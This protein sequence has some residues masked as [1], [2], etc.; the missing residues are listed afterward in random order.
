MK[1]IKIYEKYYSINNDTL[2][3]FIKGVCK[4]FGNKY[5]FYTINGSIYI[6]DSILAVIIPNQNIIICE[7]TLFSTLNCIVFNIFKRDLEINKLLIDYFS[8]IMKIQY[9][10]HDYS[11]IYTDNTKLSI[12]NF[13]KLLVINKYNL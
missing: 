9:D 4:L 7:I 6:H 5:D 8:S 10:N 11:F 3:R 12:N 13:K 1:Y 2:I